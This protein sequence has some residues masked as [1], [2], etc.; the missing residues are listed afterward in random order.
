MASVKISVPYNL[1]FHALKLARDRDGAVSY[2]RAVMS[3]IFE[4][5]GLPTDLMLDEDN[6]AGLIVAWYHE[7][8]ARGG[9]PDPAAE[10]L[11]AEVLAEDQAGQPFS[12][13]PGRA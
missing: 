1:E 2:D 11:I 4:A 5:S 7:H 10:D 9:D 13:P 8:R 3:R 6:V 12:L